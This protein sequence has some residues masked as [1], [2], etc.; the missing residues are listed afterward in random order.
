MGLPMVKGKVT[1]SKKIGDLQTPYLAW[2]L[3][4]LATLTFILSWAGAFPTGVVEPWFAHTLFPKISYLAGRFADA[5]SFSW[6][7]VG[8]PL[9]LVLLVALLR[10]RRFRLLASLVAGAGLLD[11]GRASSAPSPPPGD[12]EVVKL[13]GGQADGLK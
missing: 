6:L 3:P 7:D 9:T 10:G 5:V 4:A 1:I 11:G 12:R 8:I 2:F 13:S